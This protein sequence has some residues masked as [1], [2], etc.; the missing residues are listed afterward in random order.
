VRIN[1]KGHLVEEVKGKLLFSGFD[2]SIYREN[3]WVQVWS[4]A[5]IHHNVTIGLFKT[6]DN[7]KSYRLVLEETGNLM[8]YDAVGA[9]IWCTDTKCNHRLGYIFPEVY[10]VPTNMKT[11][12]VKDDKHNSIDP[13]IE[14]LNKTSLT[15]LSKNNCN[16]FLMS[17]QGLKSLSNYF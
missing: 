1:E 4:S 16:S 12:L 10:L 8:L 3:E 11:P 14:W 15:S 7:H 13:N 6:P 17:N 2:D 9:L 5:P